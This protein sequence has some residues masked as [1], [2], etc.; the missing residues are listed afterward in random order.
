MR[1]FQPSQAFQAFFNQ[2]I[3]DAERPVTAG[4]Y[5]PMIPDFPDPEEQA[6]AH[7]QLAELIRSIHA[8]KQS[9]TTQTVNPYALDPS[10][11][12]PLYPESWGTQSGAP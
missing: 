2:I 12:Q 4:T 1:L 10:T 3:A 5:T 8:M 9:V 6:F 7:T 11:G